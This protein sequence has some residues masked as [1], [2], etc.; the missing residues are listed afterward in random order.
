MAAIDQHG[1]DVLIAVK[2]VPGSSRTRVAGMIGQRVKIA[3]SAPPE[4]G[5]ANDALAKYIAGLCGLRTREVTVESG[6]TAPLKTIR[7]KGSTADQIRTAL[8]LLGN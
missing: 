4:K 6:L 7:V 8:G 5:K 3:V 1:K 2:V